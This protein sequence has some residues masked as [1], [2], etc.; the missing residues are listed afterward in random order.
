METVVSSTIAE[1]LSWHAERAAHAHHAQHP[2]DS[3]P[4]LRGDEYRGKDE[5]LFCDPESQ[6]PDPIVRA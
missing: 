1:T 6:P 5:I 3:V 2:H 4:L